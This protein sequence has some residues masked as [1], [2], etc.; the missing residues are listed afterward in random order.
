M[1]RED[2]KSLGLSDEQIDAIMGLHGKSTNSLKEKNEELEGRLTDLTKQLGE[3]NTAIEG[4]KKLDVDGIKSAAADWK[5]KYEEGQQESQKK[6]DA[7]RFDHALEASLTGTHR[8]KNA[9]AVKALLDQSTLKLKDD[10]SI[11]GLEDQVKKIVTENDYLFN[12][13]PEGEGEAQDE[14]PRIIS[15]GANH[16]VTGDALMSAMRKGAR[17]P[18]PKQGT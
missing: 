15:G 10:G 8:A 13:A 18:E 14:T 11:D 12:P 4:F 6:L 5:K 17:M 7:L 16:Q 1:K 3:A 2:L 9:K